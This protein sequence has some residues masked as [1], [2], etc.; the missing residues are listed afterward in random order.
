MFP[1]LT[2]AECADANQDGSIK[3]EDSDEVLEYVSEAAASNIT[4]STLVNSMG[5]KK[6][7]YEY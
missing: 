1:K 7:T 5:Y 6:V 2:Y 3:P 4:M